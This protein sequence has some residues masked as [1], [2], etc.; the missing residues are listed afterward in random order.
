MTLNETIGYNKYINMETTVIFADAYKCF[1]KLNLKN[2][3]IDL[4]T[5]VG[6]KE[7]MDIYRLNRIGNA[8]ISTPIGNATI[9]TPIGNV[10]PVKANEIVRQ[11]T[12]IGPKLC[13]INTD[14]INNIGRKCITNIG[15]NI[16]VDMLTYVDDITY[17]NSNLVQIKKAVANLRCMGKCKGLTFNTEKNKTELMIIIINI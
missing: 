15:P 16:R 9:S 17:V 5:M 10:G 13:C 8:T 1:D 6:A 14:K 7:A 12:I 2:C 4:Y 11:G 3:I